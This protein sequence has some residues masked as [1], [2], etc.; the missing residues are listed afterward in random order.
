M[1]AERDQAKLERLRAMIDEGIRAL[2]RGDFVEVDDVDLE[3]FLDSLLNAPN[4]L[5]EKTAGN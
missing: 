5:T 3:A 4:E 2:E 1:A